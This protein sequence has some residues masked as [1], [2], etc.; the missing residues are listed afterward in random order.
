MTLRRLP[1][2][3]GKK[4]DTPQVGDIGRWTNGL[5]KDKELGHMAIFDP[6][7]GNCGKKNRTV[8][9]VW[10]ASNSTSDRNFGAAHESFFTDREGYGSV[11][12]YRFWK[13]A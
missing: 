2:V 4:V 6:K 13:A 7:V 8:G 5:P 3:A 10:S 11:T 9:N 1:L 12:W